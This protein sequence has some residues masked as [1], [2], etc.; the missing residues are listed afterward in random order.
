[1]VAKAATN[2]MT[3]RGCAT[4]ADSSASRVRIWSTGTWLSSSP[5][6]ARTAGTRLSG[7]TADRTT[8]AGG[9]HVS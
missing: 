1:M 3:K 4:P 9:N 6:A 5:T 8:S 7:G 2:I